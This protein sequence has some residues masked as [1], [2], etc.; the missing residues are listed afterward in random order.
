MALVKM[1]REW[2]LAEDVACRIE[3]VEDMP[4]AWRTLDS[5][6]GTDHTPEAGWRPEP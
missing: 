3:G 6:Y 5:I 2:N 4:G 1:F